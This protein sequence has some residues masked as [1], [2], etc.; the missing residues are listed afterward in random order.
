MLGEILVKRVS[1]DVVIDLGCTMPLA[2]CWLALIVRIF[3]VH[4]R[5]PKGQT[6]RSKNNN[7]T[8]GADAQNQQSKADAFNV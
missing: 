3:R 6:P 1:P 5:G 4:A 7:V 2:W 8:S